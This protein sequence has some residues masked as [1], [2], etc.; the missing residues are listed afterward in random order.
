VILLPAIDIQDGRAVRLVQGRFD[1]PTVYA[2]DPLDAARAW[3]RDGARWLH[4]VDLD[5][6]RSGAP[7]NLDQLRR[8]TEAI[9]VPV[10]FGGG[11]RTAGA[12]HEALDAGAQ[13]IVIGTAAYRNPALLDELL[14][15][16]PERV[17]VAVD[18]RGN[19]VVTAGWT[20][21]TGAGPEEVIAELTARGVRRFAYTDVDRDGMLD[22]VDADATRRLAATAGAG[23]GELIYSGGVGSLSDLRALADLRLPNLTGVIVGKALYERRF[24]VAEG[25]SALDV[26]RP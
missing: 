16:E 6:A 14:S 5:A 7:V 12:C 10:Q 9:D 22:G 1:E 24:T 13:R 4:I 20:E 21:T 3:T 2:D 15:A 23:D 8:I 11:L 19:A 18:V 17:V 26:E 25:Q